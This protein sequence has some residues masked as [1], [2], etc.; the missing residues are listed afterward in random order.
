VDPTELGTYSSAI[1][2]DYCLA[3]R[4]NGVEL[5]ANMGYLLPEDPLEGLK[6]GDSAVWKCNRCN[7][8]TAAGSFQP[9]VEKL[10]RLVR[11]PIKSLE[12]VEKL[13]KEYSGK[14]LHPNHWIL[15]EASRGVIRL[16]ESNKERGTKEFPFET[17][18]TH[19]LYRLTI[20]NVL[21]PG[22]SL[23]RAHLQRRFVMAA[24][25]T[26]QLERNDN[27]PEE[28]AN[29]WK[30]CYQFTREAH[31]FFEYFKDGVPQGPVHY[32][33]TSILIEDLEKL[34]GELGL[35]VDGDK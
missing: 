12:M 8:Q 17:F 18:K 19:L 13:M 35:A 4:R 28:K 33:L 21:S 14:V 26:Q 3:D 24:L 30:T 31:L 27:T 7:K 1:A 16:W 6:Q 34:T 10:G 9:T 25:I 15:Q 29:L 2:C 20:E 32:F 23:H 11:S 22:I 5:D